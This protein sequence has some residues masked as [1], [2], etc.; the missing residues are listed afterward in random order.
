MSIAALKVPAHDPAFGTITDTDATA[1]DAP[2]ALPDSVV[3]VL[4]DL[5]GM[6]DE[7]IGTAH[8]AASA[9]EQAGFTPSFEGMAA[10]N[11]QPLLPH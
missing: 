4:R 3:S 5:F 8:A 2:A 1:S 10:G 11:R 6:T 9:A 7:E